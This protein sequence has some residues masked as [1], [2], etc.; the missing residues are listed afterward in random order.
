MGK[1]F[2][3]SKILLK[4][5]EFGP[6]LSRTIL[7]YFTLWIGPKWPKNWYIYQSKCQ[8]PHEQSYTKLTTSIVLMFVFRHATPDFLAPHFWPFL[9]KLA[10]VGRF[11]KWFTKWHKK[12]IG[13]AVKELFGAKTNHP[14]RPRAWY[15]CWQSNNIVHVWGASAC[16]STLADRPSQ[17]T[18]L[19]TICAPQLFQKSEGDVL[20][21]KSVFF[22]RNICLHALMMARSLL[23]WPPGATSGSSLMLNNETVTAPLD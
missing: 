21:F 2:E 22:N 18:A 15:K 17:G 3:K 4:L 1:L 12:T 19:A 20:V 16:S 13:T 9:T 7:V 6:S 8:K 23:N 11:V 10:V 14:T 5:S